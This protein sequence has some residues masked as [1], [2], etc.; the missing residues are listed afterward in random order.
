[1][2]KI[3]ILS[4]L[5]PVVSLAQFR[6]TGL[7]SLLFR[8]AQKDVVL[9]DFY[10]DWC[11]PCKEMKPILAD[12][13]REG[14]VI[15]AINFDNNKAEAQK[16]GVKNLPTFIVL[17]DGKEIGREVGKVSKVRLVQMIGVKPS[18][19]PNIVTPKIPQITYRGP[20]TKSENSFLYLLSKL[21]NE[22]KIKLTIYYQTNKGGGA[23][24]NVNGKPIGGTEKEVRDF[25]DFLLK[26]NPKPPK[27]EP[28]LDKP[29]P[30]T[31]TFTGDETV[32]LINDSFELTIVGGR[33]MLVIQV[34]ICGIG[35][36]GKEYCI[37]KEWTVSA[38]EYRE[39]RKGPKKISVTPSTPFNPKEPLSQ[40]RGLPDPSKAPRSPQIFK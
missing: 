14:Y 21:H 29:I 25:Y 39:L 1:M 22:G 11:G 32:E 37:P 2:K 6:P 10:A 34:K 24:I 20:N 18:L 26:L 4:L 15:K 13:E 16:Y 33:P 28:T 38:E 17:V 36:D 9:L 35:E 7:V 8:Q 31:N 5:I 27:I 19:S 30:S 3:I 40:P 12:L 23:L